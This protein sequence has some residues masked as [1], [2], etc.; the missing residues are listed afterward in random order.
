MK[1]FSEID[2]YHR[3]LVYHV[4]CFVAKC[5][6]GLLLIVPMQCYC[7]FLNHH[8]LIISMINMI[9]SAYDDYDKK[10]PMRF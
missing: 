7:A 8:T 3:R 9:M 6:K 4:S 5:R 1:I 10:S 2:C